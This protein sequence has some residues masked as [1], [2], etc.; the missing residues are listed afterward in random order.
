MGCLGNQL[1]IA[2]LLLSVYGIYCT[3]YVTVF[4]GVPA[5]RNA[6]IPLFCATKNR[7]T[8]GTTQCLPDNGDYSE[9]A[10]NVTESFDAWENTVTEQA[11]EDVWQLFETSIKPCVKLSPLCITMRC[12][13]SETDKW[14]LTKSSTITTTAPTTPNT[15]STK[16]IDM[17]NET[18][19]CIVHDNC[20]GLEQ[21]Q[22]IGCKFNMTGLKRDKTKEYNE[23]WYSTDLVCEQGNSTDNESICY[24]NHCNTSIIQ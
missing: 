5:W 18:S 3:Q 24:M 12:N 23:T 9:L 1:L 22:M 15:T 21:E 14:G 10:L 16:S 6:T 17:V 13:K 7:D 4:Y 19:S 8:W 11:I 2:I 20:T